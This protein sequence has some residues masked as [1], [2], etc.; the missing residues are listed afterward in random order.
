MN[1]LREQ[2]QTKRRQCDAKKPK[3]MA[4]YDSLAEDAE[5]AFNKVISK[6]KSKATNVVTLLKNGN[7]YQSGNIVASTLQFCIDEF[8]QIEKEC[9]TLKRL[10]E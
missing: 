8:S 6:L 1:I 10:Y 7:A 4:L 5:D 3:D 9:R 2:L